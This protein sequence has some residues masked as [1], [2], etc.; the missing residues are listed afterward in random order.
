MSLDDKSAYTQGGCKTSGESVWE[1]QKFTIV[2]EFTHKS[3]RSVWKPDTSV[4]NRCN[5]CAQDG[6]WLIRQG[7][8]R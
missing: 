5:I 1:N 6:M 8:A 2:Q 3:K 7:N 4:L